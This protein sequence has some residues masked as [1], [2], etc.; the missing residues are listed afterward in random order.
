MGK[1]GSDLPWCAEKQ[2]SSSERMQPLQRNRRMCRRNYIYPT[3]S[4]KARVWIPGWSAWA[5]S[6]M[7]CLD[8]I[9]IA[10]FSSHDMGGEIKVHME[11]QVL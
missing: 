10:L 8:I 6:N 3:L 1:C 7:R 5:E 2:A 11:R 4:R 9:P